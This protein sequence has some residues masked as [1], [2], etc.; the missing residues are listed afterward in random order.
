[1]SGRGT[2][3]ARLDGTLRIPFTELATIF[4]GSNMKQIATQSGVVLGIIFVFAQPV[5]ALDLSD[6]DLAKNCIVAVNLYVESQ[7]KGAKLTTNKFDINPQLFDQPY[8]VPIG[9][10][11][12]T[13]LP[14]AAGV[15]KATLIVLLH[16]NPD[17]ASE[18][19]YVDGICPDRTGHKFKYIKATKTLDFSSK[20]NERLTLRFH[21]DDVTLPNT[22]WMKPPGD[23]I[24]MIEIPVGSQNPPS[25]PS[26]GDWCDNTQLKDVAANKT[27]MWFTMCAHHG[28]PRNFEYT[29]QLL[30]NGKVVVIDPQIINRPL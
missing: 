10:R 22:T 17:F 20:K 25:K 26:S 24:S 23:S 14:F 5:Y 8:T 21:L 12:V 30:V 15:S 28:T 13:V 29:L 27:D 9:D 1:M 11:A 6:S 3:G 16:R 7:L 2:D 18:Q 4:E 19:P